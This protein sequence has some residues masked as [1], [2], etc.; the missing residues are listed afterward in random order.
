MN[1]DIIF[2]SDEYYHVYSRGVDKRKIFIDEKDH[3]RFVK[4]LYLAN[5]DEPISFKHAFGKKGNK[6]IDEVKKAS[7]ITFIGSWCLMPNHFHLL[8]KESPEVGPRGEVGISI[9]MKKLLTAYSMYFN[10]R[11]DRTGAL[12]EGNFKAKHLDHDQYLKYQFTYI[13]LNPIS[14]IDNGWKNKKIENKQKAKDFLD[15]YKYSS[16]LDYCGVDR[17]E[18][19]ILNKQAFPEYFKSGLDFR[20]MIDE[21]IN[22]DPEDRPREE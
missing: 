13:H 11:H 2:S 6:R 10:T 7:E 16:Y 5:S 12:F 3:N 4:L 21:W 8:L 9:F 1:R 15:Q 17:P 22:N 20:E 19:K 18:G 14:I